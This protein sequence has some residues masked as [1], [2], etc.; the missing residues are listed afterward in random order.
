MGAIQPRP[1][2]GQA[3]VH[4]EGG[5]DC[6]VCVSVGGWLAHTLGLSASKRD[7]SGWGGGRGGGGGGLVFMEGAEV[8]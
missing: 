5:L 2:P 1:Y 7:E 3:S 8:C 4:V 6:F